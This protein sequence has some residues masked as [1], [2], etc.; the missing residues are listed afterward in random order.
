MKQIIISNKVWQKD[1]KQILRKKQIKHIFLVCTKSFKRQ[2]MYFEMIK[3]LAEYNIT[4]F[5]EFLPNP[6]Y[7]SIIEGCEIFKSR[8]CDFIIAAGG[9]SCMDIAKCIKLFAYMNKFGNYLEQP[10]VENNIS[11]LAIPTTAGSGS[12]ATQ[13]AVVY[14]NGEKQSVSHKSCIPEYVIFEPSLLETLPDYQKKAA[15]FDTL[16]HAIESYWSVN[17]TSKSREYSKI[18]IQ[19]IM[20]NKDAYV[21]NDKTCNREMLK[22][23]NFAGKAINISKTTAGHAMSY[24]L[25]SLY[26]LAHGHAVMCIIPSLWLFMLKNLDNCTDARGLLY[27]QEIFDEISMCLE[28]KNSL[29]AVEMLENMIIDFGMEYPILNNVEEL[30]ILCDSVNIERLINNPILL[31]RDDIKLLYI[32]ILGRNNT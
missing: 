16:S 20:K 19:L 26:G 31:T 10:I 4:E 11:I 12:E 2:E 18:A 14:Y 9:G 15:L 25:T 5:T 17:S 29:E 27:L 23:A 8:G 13:F 7:E 32:E 6:T 30:E 21:K 28:C 3:V 24:K 1:I 22:A